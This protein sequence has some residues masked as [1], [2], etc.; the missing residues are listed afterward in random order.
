[1]ISSCW[2]QFCVVVF[3][4][5]LWQ[6]VKILCVALNC[7]LFPHSLFYCSVPSFNNNT[8]FLFIFCWVYFYAVFYQQFFEM[9]VIKLSSFINPKTLWLS[10]FFDYCIKCFSHTLTFIVLQKFAENIDNHEHI[11]VSFIPFTEL[12][13]VNQIWCPNFINTVDNNALQGEFS[14]DWF[15]QFIS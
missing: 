2:N 1:M 10:A 6:Y 12:R 3:F 14:F 4:H 5:Y 9:F 8:G 11:Y 7:E 15:A 13:H